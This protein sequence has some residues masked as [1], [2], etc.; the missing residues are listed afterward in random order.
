MKGDTPLTGGI[1]L[2][3][4]EKQLRKAD[5]FVLVLPTTPYTQEEVDIL[6]SFVG[7]GGKVLLI[8]D[9]GRPNAINSV[10][11][12][13]GIQFQA[14]Y[15]YNVV[16]HDLNFL[17]I[18]VRDFR[19]DPVTEGLNTI[20]LYRAGSIRATGPPLAF[21]DTNTFSS[22]VERLEP[23]TPMVKSAD[24]RVL[25]ISDL[26]FL[27]PP[28]NTTLDN[29]RLFEN[30]AD[31]LT[32]GE[33]RFELGE[34]PHFFKDD[35]DILLGRAD[36]LDTGTRLRSVLAGAQIESE[37]QSVE[38]LTKDTVFLGLYQDSLSVAQYLDVAGV[39]VDGALRTPFTADITAEG[40]GILLL[41]KSNRRHVLVVL[42]DRLESLRS[43]VGRL[44]SG[45]FT[46]GLVSDSL[47]VYGA[48]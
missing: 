34:F 43:V 35:V 22:M 24:G 36:L 39:Q 42:G 6:K 8:A 48:P 38:D 46:S 19:P 23:L 9:P 45:A 31:F 26:T 3:S 18:F 28:Q 4:Y 20:A 27:Q 14:G 11:D 13:F 33:R 16:E 44:G 5:S 7:K 41:H 1:V 40:T 29:D 2:T 21:S 47:G 10:A 32:T 12:A 30:I 17:N 15:L 25:A 37:F